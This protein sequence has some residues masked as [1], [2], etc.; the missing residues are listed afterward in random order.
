MESLDHIRDEILHLVKAATSR[1]ALE[2]VRVAI[3]GKKGRVTALLKGL[4]SLD[5]D[6]RR[7]RG[8]A[9]NLLKDDVEAAIGHATRR[10]E[11]EALE[12]QLP[13]ER[14]D[15]TLPLRAEPAR[16]IQHQRLTVN[17]VVAIFYA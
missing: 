8:A 1:D 3:L 14:L 4:A 7:E 15:V 9:L 10:L 16:G 2:Q 5:P 6:A 12:E 13:R 11:N 17:E